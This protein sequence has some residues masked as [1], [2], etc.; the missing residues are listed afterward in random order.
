MSDR[1][2]FSIDPYDILQEHDLLI[3]RLIKANNHMNENM[4]ELVAQ[5]AELTVQFVELV[6][7]LNET[8]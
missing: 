5:H 3:Q 7:R 1:L 8:E 6:E 2:Q 4:Q